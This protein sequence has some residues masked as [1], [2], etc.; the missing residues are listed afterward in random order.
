M[1]GEEVLPEK[2]MLEKSA[3][4]KSFGYSPLG[5]EQETQT[6]IAKKQCQ[7]LDKAF[8]FDKNGDETIN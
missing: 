4:I 5:N 1:T 8:K 2:D 3:T 6:D 7:D